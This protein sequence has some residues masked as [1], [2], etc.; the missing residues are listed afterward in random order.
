[1]TDSEVKPYLGKPVRASTADGRVIAGTLHA[2]DDHG[3]GHVHYAIV[4]SPIRE[5]DAP[6]Q[7]VFH[8]ADAFT[9]IEDASGDPAA[10]E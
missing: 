4:S 7:E 3:H 9:Q 5:G 2:S 8:G 6:A 10:S 1:M